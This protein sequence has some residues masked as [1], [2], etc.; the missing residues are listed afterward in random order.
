MKLLSANTNTE[1]IYS[2]YDFPPFIEYDNPKFHGHQLGIAVCIKNNETKEIEENMLS[3]SR[4]NRDTLLQELLN[5]DLVTLITDEITQL[6]RTNDK[7]VSKT[8]Y[9]LPYRPENHSSTKPTVTDDY[10]STSMNTFYDVKIELLFVQDN[11]IKRYVTMPVQTR[12]IGMLELVNDIFDEWDNVKEAFINEPDCKWVRETDEYEA[13]FL[14]D[15]YDNCGNRYDI[16]F[17]QP[18]ELKQALVSARVI[19][20]HCHIDN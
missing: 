13:G 15:F 17:S 2:K 3:K 9:Y 19:S 18:D 8:I 10:I 4:N 5:D 7:L 16:T 11:G 12:N 6:N 20:L 14:V 1:Y